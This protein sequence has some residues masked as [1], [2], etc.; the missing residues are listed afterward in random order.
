MSLN[1]NKKT[2]LRD[3]V[4]PRNSESNASKNTNRPEENTSPSTK[5]Q[6]ASIEAIAAVTKAALPRITKERLTF[7]FPDNYNFC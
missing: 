3:S 2:C 7:L 5:P 4:Y 1:K 6:K